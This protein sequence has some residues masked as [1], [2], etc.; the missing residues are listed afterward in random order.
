MI[1][2]SQ[3]LIIDQTRFNHEI[4]NVD[5]TQPVNMNVPSFKDREKT[6]EDEYIRKR[7]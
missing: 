6:L 7:E 4:Y 5:D 1:Y 3:H 2:P